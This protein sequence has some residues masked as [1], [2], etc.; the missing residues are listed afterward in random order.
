MARVHPQRNVG[1]SAIAAE[2]ALTDQQAD[3]DPAREL[4]HCGGSVSPSSVTCNV[5]GR[6]TAPS[7][8]STALPPVDWIRRDLND[9]AARNRLRVP[10]TLD[11]R[12]ATTAVIDGRLARVFCSNDYLGLRFD[13]R[14]A[15]AAVAAVRAHGTGAGAS[16]LVAGS[17]PIHETAERQLATLVRCPA[18]LLGSAGYPTNVAT[19]ASLAGPDDVVFSD[20]LNHASIIDGCRLSRARVAVYP[21]R[22]TNALARAIPSHRPFRRGWVVTET[23]FSMDGDL[24]PVEALRELCDREGLMLFVDEAHALGVIGAHGE[25]VAAAAGV[26]AEAVVGTLGKALGAS[27]AF[28][29][30][31]DDLRAYLWNHSRG[32]V[33]STAVPPAAAAVAAEAAS[34]VQAASE[35]RVALGDN[36]DCLI[37]ALARAGVH[38]AHTPRS[39]IVPVVL[40]D[41]ARA[42][43]T[44]HAL[45]A[46]G[47]FVQPIRPPTVPEGTARLRITVSAAHSI[48]DI[49]Q[50]AAALAE[51]MR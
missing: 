35:R 22:D 20:A 3:Q 41:D 18:A 31:T 45:L 50:L 43:A 47:F 33:F 36:V 8:T 11:Y 23:L 13:P 25:G 42:V 14:L 48:V 26:T 9:H 15:D 2:M 51:V 10:T 44:A 46:R 4:V 6:L 12:S 38:L 37:A 16:R 21:H 1:L 28:V 5:H 30:G 40:G 32:F 29:A 39:P 7:E 24:A 27:G 49:E 34:L 19:I 17:Q